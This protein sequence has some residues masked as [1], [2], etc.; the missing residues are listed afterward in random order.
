MILLISICKERLSE[1]EFVRSLERLLKDHGCDFVV[2]NF[3]EVSEKDILDS[4][5]VIF[6][7]TALKDF[8]YFYHDFSWLRRYYN[9]VLGIGAGA[10]VI[11]KEFRTPFEERTLIGKYP[12]NVLHENP[13]IERHTEAYFLISWVPILTKEFY[14]L[15]ETEGIT[16]MFVHKKKPFFG[17]VFHP[18]VLNK[19]IIINF[20]NLSVQKF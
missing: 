15:T 2:R 12:V 19:E 11:A 9:P 10:N 3:K 4:E 20:L 16:S 7:G 18:E 6:T 5:K 1:Y 14:P 17:V 8:D 13:L